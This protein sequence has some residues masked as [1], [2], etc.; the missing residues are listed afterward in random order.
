M[1]TKPTSV[2][3]RMYQV[4]F[5][6]C[7]LLTFF[8]KAPAKSRHVLIDFG[9]TEAPDGR[10]ANALLT[11][12]ANSIAET[13]GSDPF[14]VV[15]THRHKDHIAGF[16]PGKNGKGPG[17]IIA[18]LKPTCVIQPWTEQPDLAVDAKA[19]TNLKGLA[20]RRETLASM[21]GIAQHAIE[22]A[23]PRLQRSF[24]STAVAKQLAFIG[25]DNIAN[26]GAVKNLMTM[27]KNDYVYAKKKSKLNT[28]LPGV[29]VTVLGPPTVKQH[30]GVRK[31]RANDPNEFWLTQ[32]K[33]LGVGQ[34]A[35]AASAM[36][37][38]FPGHQYTTGGR[39]PNW[40]R[41]IVQSLRNARGDQLLELVRSL[42]TAMNNTSVI[43]L[44][45]CG[46]MKFL[47]PGDAQI[48]NWEYALAQDDLLALLKDV[49]VYKVGHHGSR[50][51]TPKTLWEN[52]FPKGSN[53]PA[54]KERMTS[55]MSTKPGKHG[56]PAFGT[57]VPRSKLVSALN[58]WT[59]LTSTEEMKDELFVEEKYG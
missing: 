36:D 58:G 46:G 42:D 16:D 53:K 25:E 29:N 30:D 49:S 54:M 48:E 1:A 8:Y 3:V 35:K 59:R 41:W 7:F 2:R 47:F 51:A 21:Q 23:L 9:T 37:D 34:T 33:A 26:P 55:F 56:D 5:G 13:V 27:G 22:V 40:A 32:A 44:F 10:N 19:P 28:F 15:A 6:D 12:I 50:N 11:D 17:A 31:Q 45:E 14:A 20:A 43:L 24:Q 52:W 4:G 39:A 18:K 57:E 38:V